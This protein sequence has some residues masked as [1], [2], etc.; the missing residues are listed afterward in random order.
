MTPSSSV[1]G[2][3]RAFRIRQG[4]SIHTL[5]YEYDVILQSLS[6]TKSENLSV[7][8]E[9]SFHRKHPPMPGVQTF[10]LRDA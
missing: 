3:W 1:V 6:K 9:K 8:Y 10:R 5:L 7:A 4:G 2:V